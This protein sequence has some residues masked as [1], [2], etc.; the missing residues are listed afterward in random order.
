MVVFYRKNNG[1]DEKYVEML[2]DDC[3]VLIESMDGWRWDW[4]IKRW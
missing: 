4:D 3:A 1:R 2:E